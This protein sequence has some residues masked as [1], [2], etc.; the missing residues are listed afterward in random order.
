MLFP[1]FLV[2]T[3]YCFKF[4]LLFFSLFLQRWREINL[5]P[6]RANTCR[7]CHQ[8]PLGPVTS[9]SFNPTTLHPQFLPNH[10]LPQI[11]ALYH[12]S[13][14]TSHPNSHP[15]WHHIFIPGGQLHVRIF[16]DH[17]ESTSCNLNSSKDGQRGT[18][19]D[20]R[21]HARQT[22]TR[23]GDTGGGVRHHLSVS[24]RVGESDLGKCTFWNPA[25]S[26]SLSEKFPRVLTAAWH[27]WSLKTQPRRP[28]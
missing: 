19:T 27:F 3:C 14:K 4:S 8:Q 7:C 6:T 18:R 12:L 17:A 11:P 25:D 9:P 20:P 5:R 2:L 24:M 1:D 16:Q 22:S 26:S 21:T 23:S 13:L 10:T 28:W 15:L